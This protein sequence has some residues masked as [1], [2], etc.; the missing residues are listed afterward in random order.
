MVGN[1][2]KNG[3][4]VLYWRTIVKPH[5][6]YL[7]VI[8]SLMF[9]AGL[10][11]TATL[12]MG[13]PLIEVATSSA[14]PDNS[15]LAAGFI[16]NLLLKAG[17]PVEEK[18]KF[19]FALL[20]IVSSITILK[21]TFQMVSKYA[22]TIIAQNFRRE[23]KLKLLQKILH[24]SYEYIARRSRG[25]ILYDINQPSQSLYQFIHILGNFL[26]NLINAVFMIVLM[27]YLSIPATITIT[28]IGG[29]WLYSWRC[30]FGPRM[31]LVGKEIYE[32]N[33][34]MGKADVD[35]IDGIRVVKS[36]NLQSKMLS[37]QESLLVREMIPKKKAALYTQGLLFISEFSAGLIVVVLGGITF[38]L[39]LFY[40][41]FARMVV[42]LLAVR[43]AS[44][45]LSAV[46]QSYLE[47][48]KEFKSVET[49]EQISFH[50]PQER[51]SGLE[52]FAIQSICFK[53]LSFSYPSNGSDKGWSLGNVNINAS[54]GEAIAIV[55]PTGSGKS[56]LV[57]IL[58]GFYKP[59]S[60]SVMVNDISLDDI[61][62][63]YWR[64]KV[65]YVSQDIFLF[66]ESILQN[67]ILWD[68]S[69]NMEEV[70]RVARIAQIHDFISSLPEGY[71]TLVGDRGLKL[72]GGQCQRIAIARVLLKKPDVIIFDE[73][74]SALDNITEKAVY[75]AIRFFKNETISIIIAHRLTSLQHVS[76]IFVLDSGRIVEQGTHDSLMKASGVYYRLYKEGDRGGKKLESFQ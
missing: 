66:N 31:Q 25:A 35:M 17:Y 20:I 42:L 37:T 76:K 34:T 11:E 71:N 13:V 69:V 8:V 5:F 28:V 74:T 63:N 32:L 67:I 26:S 43:K 68:E 54:K 51:K 50:T 12:G 72:S 56:T 9:L 75:N 48:K 45:A 62:L 18:Y 60:G 65:G 44:P 52:G 46:G 29:L 64:E 47:L 73:A 23:Y 30:L 4:F 70:F 10:M 41:D 14:Q 40:L 57:N 38:G 49:I 7:I 16:K 3:A 6:W 1:K 58:L 39:G 61:H 33:Q 53:N 59:D 22:T 36:N 27:V 55:G 2:F 21:A 15:S 19:I 24:A